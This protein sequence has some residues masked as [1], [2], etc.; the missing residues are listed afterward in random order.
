VDA[1][2]PKA[3]KV[4]ETAKHGLN[5]RLQLGDGRQVWHPTRAQLGFTLAPGVDPLGPSSAARYV[6]DR[7]KALAYFTSIA[8]YVQRSPR[9]ARPTIVGKYVHSPTATKSSSEPIP[10]KVLPARDGAGLEIE[11]AADLVVA[12]IT[13]DPRAYH[14]VLPVR[15]WPAKVTDATLSGIDSR[16]GHF[17]THFNPG[18]VGR[19]KT[20]KRAIGLIDGS[21]VAPG[22]VFSVNQTVGER[23]EARGFGIGHVFVNGQ[24][25][26]DVGGGMCQVATTLFNSSLLANMKIVE[27]FQH[28]RTVPY[29]KAGSDATVWWGQKDFKFQNDTD[30]PLYIS[31]TTVGSYAVCDLYGKGDSS[32]TVEVD[33]YQRRNGARDYFGS[34]TR[35][36]TVG[37]QKSKTY[38]AFSRYKWT[39]ALDYSR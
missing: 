13:R 30:T 9:D 1:D 34:I 38:E 25:K 22:T 33:A 29:V 15:T 24:M 11:K 36:T 26:K 14:I 23:T 5:S 4:T 6:G 39:A 17:V 7:S 28:V 3:A 8:P 31:Y 27:R 20:V 18:E 2:A 16:I 12:T 10:A 37:G 21:I 32:R 35:Y 19:T